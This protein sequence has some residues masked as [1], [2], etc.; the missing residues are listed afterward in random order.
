MKSNKEKYL[1]I[2]LIIISCILFLIAIYMSKNS[3][4][5]ITTNKNNVVDVNNNSSDI[6]NNLI[7]DTNITKEENNT[8]I[9]NTTD[10]NI[11]TTNEDTIISYFETEINTLSLS[12]DSN[13]TS[14]KSRAKNTFTNIIDFIFYDKEI[15]GYTFSSLTNTAKLKI[16][17]LALTLDNIIDNKFPDYKDTIKDKY[18]DIKG[19]LA[20][21]YLEV[22]SNLCS[23]VGENTCNQ[24]KEDFNNMKNSFGFTW[25][26][27]KEL[28][29]SGS[30]KIKDFYEKWRVD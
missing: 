13:D 21:K 11:P 28:A 1:I 17:K 14:I 15:N 12:S 24:A 2:I 20:I 27:I 3:N 19:S 6:D 7:N 8:I 26:L 10:N 16:I 9:D 23:A 30:S 18:T 5:N 25:D 29:S 22:L 4:N